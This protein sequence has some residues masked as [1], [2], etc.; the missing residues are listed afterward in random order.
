MAPPGVPLEE[1]M[2][3]PGTPAIKDGYLVPSDAPGFGIEVTMGW[4][5]GVAV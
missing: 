5:E 4:Q 3:L 1:M 2:L